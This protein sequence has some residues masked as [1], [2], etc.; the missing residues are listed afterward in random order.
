MVP[1]IQGSGI[2]VHIQ[3]ATVVSKIKQTTMAVQKKAQL[4]ERLCNKMQINKDI[5]DTSYYMVWCK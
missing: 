4:E 1:L 2:Q 5:F 3:G